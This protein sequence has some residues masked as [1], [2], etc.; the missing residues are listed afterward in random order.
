MVSCSMRTIII[1]PYIFGV[2]LPTNS[3]VALF[4]SRKREKSERWAE[5][6]L[7]LS[8]RFAC[9]FADEFAKL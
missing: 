5:R 8:S 6:M 9:S 1:M 7:W 4:T 2:C 3:I